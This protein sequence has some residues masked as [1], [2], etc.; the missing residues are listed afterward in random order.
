MAG[1]RLI[2]APRL[3]SARWQQMAS[4]QES[5]NQMAIGGS[6]RPTEKIAARQSTGH[7]GQKKKLRHSN[8]RIAR[9]QKENHGVA[10]GVSRWP[11]EKMQRGN[12]WIAPAKRKIMAWQLIDGA[13]QKEKSQRG[14]R[15]IA[16]AK[17]KIPARQST[18]YAGQKKKI[19][20]RQSGYRT[21]QKKNCGSAIRVS[22]LP[23]QKFAQGLRVAPNGWREA[24]GLRHMV[25]VRLEDP[26]EWLA[27]G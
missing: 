13:G 20:V 1:A 15:W 16:P 17:R 26:A 2:I 6:R 4:A 10:I 23:L 21:G 5:N 14:N 7:T 24:W 8:R 18:D 22:R 25:G 9:W 27:R 19:A 12:W 3:V 11:K